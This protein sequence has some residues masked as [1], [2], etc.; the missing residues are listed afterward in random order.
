MGY[1]TVLKPSHGHGQ[2]LL[3][4]WFAEGEDA[5]ASPEVLHP[6]AYAS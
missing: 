4:R 6:A 5:T 3:K 2:C 1:S